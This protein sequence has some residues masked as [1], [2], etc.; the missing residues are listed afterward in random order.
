MPF[1]WALLGISVLVLSFNSGFISRNEHGK[2]HRD[3]NRR[4]EF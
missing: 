3:H 2:F 4:S 1:C